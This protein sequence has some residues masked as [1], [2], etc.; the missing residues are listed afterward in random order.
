MSFDFDRRID[1]S[2]TSAYKWDDN[3]RLFGRAELL[4]FW[5]ADMEFAT[6]QPI[7]DA[8]RERTGHPVLGYSTRGREYIATVQDW[9]RRR[10]RWDVPEEWLVFCPPSSIVGIHGLVSVL[11][12]PGD[13]ILVPTPTYG[14]L[15][16]IAGDGGRRLLACPMPNEAGWFQLDIEAL[17]SALLPDTRLL[18]LCSPNNPTGRVYTRAELEA[19][20]E[21]A[22]R[23]DLV[24]V[25]DEVHND[26]IMPGH[27]HIPYG[28]VGGERSVTVISP[29]KAFNTAGIPQAT[30]IIPDREVRSQFV[31][32]LE[33]VQLTHDSTFGEIGMLAAYRHC[34]AWLDAAIDYIAANHTRVAE[35]LDECVP[36]C[37]SR[38]AEATYLAWLDFRESRME[39]GELMRRLVDIGGVGLY[40]GTEFGEAGRGF[41]RMNVACPRSMLDQGLEGIRLAMQA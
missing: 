5:V 41:F 1:R 29:N 21:L 40:S 6:P 2:G 12:Q 23:R 17:T 38:P 32:Y 33:T 4:P 26:L 11:S 39:Q 28:T 10:H 3:E 20:A 16:T 22:E 13:S 31:R 24:V 36:G 7:L 14:P 19:V 27:T 15:L 9:L 35:F 30:L 37:S 25:A 34:E 8:V 18:L